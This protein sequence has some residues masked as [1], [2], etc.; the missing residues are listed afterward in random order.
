MRSAGP[1]LTRLGLA[2][3]TLDRARRTGPDEEG[4]SDVRET[5]HGGR[6]DGAACQAKAEHLKVRERTSD[7]FVH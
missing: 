5:A 3:R 4:A 7:G 1:L 6:M 2:I